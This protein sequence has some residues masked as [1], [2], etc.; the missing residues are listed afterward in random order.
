MRPSNAAFLKLIDDCFGQPV[1]SIGAV[2]EILATQQDL[3]A[4]YFGSI[5]AQP[6]LAAAIA[7][8]S[9][10]HNNGFA[11]LILHQDELG[12]CVR[13][14]AW[15]DSAAVVEQASNVHNHRW[16]FASVNLSGAGLMSRNFLRDAA[17]EKYHIFSYSRKSLD[18]AFRPLG[19]VGLSGQRPVMVERGE[20]Y[21]C[22][23]SQL[24]IVNP[25]PG[26][27]MFTLVVQGP[28]RLESATIYSR[29][30]RPR[31][32]SGSQK[33]ISAEEVSTL[34]AAALNHQAGLSR[35]SAVH[36]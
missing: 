20:V 30:E 17:G 3:I 13:L 16:D 27:Q 9:Y 36:G 35:Y 34:I 14:H 5:L 22:R 2:A 25:M 21:I 28:A 32:F 15:L 7:R 6:A 4:E 31:Q 12:Y 18:L 33:S 8:R 26:P 10:W 29:S 11:K 1:E 19:T 24:H 23:T